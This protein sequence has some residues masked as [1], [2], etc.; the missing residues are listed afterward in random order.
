MNTVVA[1][2]LY[3][4]SQG[5]CN[6]KCLAKGDDGSDYVIK[7][8]VI[9]HAGGAHNK[10]FANELL[11][12]TLAQQ[13]GIFV[14]K[15]GII[16]VQRDSSVDGVGLFVAGLYFGS[17]LMEYKSLDKG[18]AVAEQIEDYDGDAIYRLHA[19]DVLLKNPDRK[20]TDVLC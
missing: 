7:V 16:E 19:F 6:P 18:T 5:G 17:R 14:P 3:P 15:C 9:S 2:G 20:A 10:G 13:L 11:A 1:T 8:G 12:H 4:F